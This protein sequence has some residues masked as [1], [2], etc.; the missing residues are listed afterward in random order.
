MRYTIYRK[1]ISKLDESCTSN[2]K[3]E[4]SN[5]T[6][7][8]PGTLRQS[9]SIFRISDLRCRIRPISK[10]YRQRKCDISLNSAGVGCCA[11]RTHAGFADS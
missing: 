11:L 8:Q 4:I 2:P 5:W 9:N 7:N 3:S 10:F 6:G 1:E